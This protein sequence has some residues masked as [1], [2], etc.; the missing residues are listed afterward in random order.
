MTPFDI[1]PDNDAGH[2]LNQDDLIAFHLHELSS[3]QERAVHRVLRANPALQAESLAIASTLRAFPK[4]EP[5]LSVDAATLDRNWQTL[6]N[7]LPLYAST[8]ATPRT[9]FSRWIFPALAASALAASAVIFSLHHTPHTSP[10]TLATNHAPS[11]TNAAPPT[12]T[13]D[14][15]SSTNP[16][17]P[18][19]AQPSSASRHVALINHASPQPPSFSASATPVPVPT[20]SATRSLTAPTTK[21]SPAE[22]P[23]ADTTVATTHPPQSPQNTTPLTLTF[24]PISQK[25]GYAHSHH[26]HITDVTLA[27]LGN[28]TPARSFTAAQGTG[29]DAVIASLTQTTTPALGMLASLHQQFRPWIGY[30]AT[31]SYSQP[32]FEYTYLIAAGS[33]SG[34]IVDENAYEL[35]GTYVIEGPRHR[36]LSTAAEAGGGLIALLPASPNLSA[37]PVADAYRPAA[38]FGASAELRL[39]RHL[40]L[41]AGYRALVYRGPSAALTYGSIVPTAPNNFTFS[42][43]PVL[44]LTYRFHE[45]NE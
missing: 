25:R 11:A 35:S 44:G 17:K 18:F 14:A 16:S 5:S 21:A 3:P 41:H 33:S 38:V 29:P 1:N 22:T 20:S 6:R 12:A 2:A 32:T 28:L 31:A 42:N 27:V 37:V 10:S 30:R 39:T 26:E 15:E 36:R 9:L 13:S 23:L 4:H 19:N 45:A 8:T 40:A 43:E 24:T 34:N 7:S